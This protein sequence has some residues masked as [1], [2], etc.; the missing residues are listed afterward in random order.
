MVYFL[1][2]EPFE[3][4]LVLLSK[5]LFLMQKTCLPPYIV[6]RARLAKPLHWGVPDLDSD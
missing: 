3:L 5:Q 4:M 1:K 2:V 6:P